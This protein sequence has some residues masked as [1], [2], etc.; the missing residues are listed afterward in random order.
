MNK[1]QLLARKKE[2]AELLADE[3]RSIDNLD[4]LETELRDITEKIGAYEKRERLAAEARDI[5]ASSATDTQNIATF[6]GFPEG[7]EQRSEEQMENEYRKA[8]MDYVLRGQEIPA[9]LRA[10]EV[11]KTTDIGA[12]IPS[13]VLNKIVEKLEASGMILPLVTRTSVKGGVTIPTSTIKP[14]A[15][16]VAE[17]AGSEKQKKTTGS[18]TFN[19]HK[20]RCAVAV[21]LETDLMALSAFEA[22]LINNIVEAMTIALEQAIVSGD[23]VGKPKGFL[24]ETPNEGQVLDVAALDY[25]ALVDAEAALPLEYENGAVYLMTKKTFMG[26]IGMVDDNKQPIA[27]VNHGVNGKPERTLLGR[28]VVLCNYVPS[29]ETATVGQAFGAL[30]NFKDYALNTNYQMSVKKYE[31]NET[32]D[33]VTKAILIADGKVVDKGSLVLLKKA[34]AA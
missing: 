16:W 5:N 27:R 11:T 15:T 28:T 14:V 9:E 3:T 6:N 12:M 29:F 21:T 8:F 23:G 19:Y 34:T 1:E 26:Y 10:N 4:E 33:Q 22:T 30:F 24:T 2:I 25:K 20:L 18:I 32:D 31:D 17:G 7:G 13:T